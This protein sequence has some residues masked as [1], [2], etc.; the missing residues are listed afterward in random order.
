MILDF[1]KIKLRVKAKVLLD[2][3]VKVFVIEFDFAFHETFVLVGF[4]RKHFAHSIA[5]PNA[6]SMN[7]RA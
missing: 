4:D 7:P 3:A 2:D 5:L 6:A 1:V